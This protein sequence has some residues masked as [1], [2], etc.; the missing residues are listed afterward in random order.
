K[1]I[2]QYFYKKGIWAE[3]Y[4]AGMGERGL[5]VPTPDSTD[6]V[7]NR[8]AVYLLTANQPAAGGAIPSKWQRL[9]GAR[10]RPANVV[11]PA[12][13]TLSS[14]KSDAGSGSS[15]S[16]SSG[17]GS[18][19]DTAPSDGDSSPDNL[20]EG[21]GE[22]GSALNDDPNP[23]AIEDEPGATKKGCQISVDTPS[24]AGVTAMLAILFGLVRRRR[25]TA[26]S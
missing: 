14:S 25:Q 26:V 24:G 1:S 2:A 15:D 4:F 22:W 9:T 11:V 5:K 8:R 3:I 18:N 16:E 17:G 13:A 20:S 10:P 6:E 7:R 23:P 21:S 19:P 12:N